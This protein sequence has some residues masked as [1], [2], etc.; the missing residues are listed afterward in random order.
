MYI[1]GGS[2]YLYVWWRSIKQNSRLTASRVGGSI[3]R[4]GPPG[5]WHTDGVPTGAPAN[6]RWPSWASIASF[7]GSSTIQYL[8]SDNI[9]Q[10]VFMNTIAFMNLFATSKVAFWCWGPFWS[11]LSLGCGLFWSPL[12]LLGSTSAKAD[13]ARSDSDNWL[14]GMTFGVGAVV[15][16]LRQ[17]D[18]RSF[19]A[20]GI[21]WQYR[22]GSVS[23]A[24]E[25]L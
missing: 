14:G 17:E 25:P 20:E 1:F 19:E 22:H 24:V 21:Q 18:F 15:V 11:L 4:D 3:F 9:G 12:D 2:Q 10:G 13:G 8:S 23:L 5:N 7:Q 16:P 6:A